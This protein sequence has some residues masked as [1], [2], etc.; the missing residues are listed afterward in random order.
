MRS[1]EEIREEIKRLKEIAAE[2]MNDDDMIS[3]PYA[4]HIVI[5]RL[6]W[7]LQ[8]QTNENGR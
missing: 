1:E 7:V 8:E 6:E 3:V 5:N 4:R 2:Y